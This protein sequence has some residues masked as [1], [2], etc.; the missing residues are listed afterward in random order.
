MF[1]KDYPF[2]FR[3]SWI[4]L[5][6]YLFPIIVEVSEHLKKRYEGH[7]NEFSPG[8]SVLEVI[9]AISVL[10]IERVKFSVLKSR[11]KWISSEVILVYFIGKVLQSEARLSKVW[12]MAI[13]SV[14]NI[15]APYYPNTLIYTMKLG[16]IMLICTR[17]RISIFSSLN[18]VDSTP[19][20]IILLLVIYSYSQYHHQ[21]NQFINLQSK[22]SETQHNFKATLNS[23]N[24]GIVAID[25]AH[26][27]VISNSSIL[28]LL[29]CT[30]AKE[31]FSAISDMKFR[32]RADKYN[33]W[34]ESDRVVDCIHYFMRLENPSSSLGVVA[35]KNKAIEIGISRISWN[36]AT[37]LLVTLRDVTEILELDKQ[38]AES[39]FKSVLLRS[40]SHELRTPTNGILGMIELIKN[41]KTQALK[42]ENTYRLEIAMN[43]CKHLIYLINDLVDF[44]QIVAG[45]LK[46]GF[47]N[48]EL[49]KLLQDC[50]SLIEIG[51][52]RRNIKLF[53][54]ISPNTPDVIYSEPNRLSQILLNL[55]SNSLKFT[56]QG[57]I[58]ILV[59]QVSQDSL[60]ISVKDTGIG[61][62]KAKQNELFRAFGKLDDD[63]SS[64][65][66]PLGCGLG[67]HISNM[68]VQYLGGD[69]MLL[70][71]SKEQG[72]EFSFKLPLKVKA[73]KLKSED[74]F[75]GEHTNVKIPTSLTS[76]NRNPFRTTEYP[77]CKSILVVDD[78][79]FNRMVMCQ[80]IQTLGITAAEAINGK[81]ALNYIKFHKNH[82]ECLKMIL[83]DYEMPDLKGYQLSQIISDMADKGEISP[84]PLMILST[85]NSDQETL[86]KS[87][88]AGMKGYIKKPCSIQDVKQMLTESIGINP[89]T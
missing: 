13:A 66:N 40:V 69:P 72:S 17:G 24:I 71:S 4:R 18:I 42:P 11:Q 34:I 82:R 70:K 87:L 12:M 33:R 61:I 15:Q 37:C 14:I 83:I 5:A 2:L 44:S 47:V 45:T 41:D 36:Q 86:K 58:S 22:L 59:K 74:S 20:I 52:T 25:S 27:S 28:K 65:L 23:I 16:V 39:N 75:I 88:D 51:A 63:L 76:F 50:M 54:R 56:E 8:I 26:M 60:L 7:Y 30:Y 77:T 68:L 9:I 81:D 29:N 32:S 62:P 57:S 53:L 73:D 79:E 31:I 67:L 38:K 43:S 84:K 10:L 35:F 21:K 6:I 80:I 64:K 89:N 85:A 46:L 1:N 48:F 55:L 3:M 19:V 78:S 49:K